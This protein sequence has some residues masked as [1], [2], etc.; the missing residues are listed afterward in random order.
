MATIT[1]TFPDAVQPRVVD[2]LCAEGGYDQLPEPKPAR[3]AFARS[4]V[5]RFVRET[6]RNYEASLA[7]E[8]AREAA[9]ARADA[10]VTIT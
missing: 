8:T 7:I 2:A 5:I 1:L 3:G 6:V 9:V 10:E 4:R